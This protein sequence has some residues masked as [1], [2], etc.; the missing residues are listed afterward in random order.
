MLAVTARVG[1]AMEGIV[2][3]MCP[4]LLGGG[5]GATAYDSVLLIGRPGVGKT[6]LLR[7]LA[8][9]LSADNRLVV[10]VV[11]K[12]CE[13][14]GDGL[15]PHSVIGRRGPGGSWR[16]PSQSVE[17]PHGGCGQ[18]LRATC[19]CAAAQ[20]A[21][22]ACRATGPAGPDFEGGGREPDA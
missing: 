9:C 14:A 11:D 16:T 2:D 1:R 6:T 20:C 18:C 22:D 7:E 12:T 13:I 8:R 5:G 17:G 19:V 4:F 15:E 10:V 3:A 21:L